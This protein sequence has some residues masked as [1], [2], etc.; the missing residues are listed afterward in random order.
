MRQ[1]KIH[2]PPKRTTVHD[3]DRRTP[4]GRILPF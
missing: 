2:K 1:I 4:A 3:L